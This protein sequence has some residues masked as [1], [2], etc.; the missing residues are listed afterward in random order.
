MATESP[1]G[2]GRTCT[3]RGRHATLTG[4]RQ[5]DRDRA[6]VAYREAEGKKTYDMVALGP[7]AVPVERNSVLL[8]PNLLSPAECKQ[9]VDDV[10]WHHRGG[11]DCLL[12]DCLNSWQEV[13]DTVATGQQEDRDSE[14]LGGGGEEE[15]PCQAAGL[16]DGPPAGTGARA[17]GS[18]AYAATGQ[19]GEPAY[20][21]GAGGYSRYMVE[22]LSP[23][24]THLF[25]SV[26][27]ERLLPL[28]S[29]EL[30]AVEEMMWRC[31]TV[32]GPTGLTFDGRSIPQRTPGVPLAELEYRYSSQE[33]AINRYTTGNFF[34]PHADHQALT[35]NVLLQEEGDA[36][37][38]GGTAFWREC[39]STEKFAH[40][41][42]HAELDDGG[43]H[44]PTLCLRPTAGVGVV[45]NG[46]VKHAGRAV[47]A[48]V[49]HVLVASLSML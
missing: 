1:G 29:T 2:G 14:V 36:F 30:P 17:G 23:A 47:T 37:E 19:Y 27:R 11:R 35:L 25:Q 33:P 3:V 44:A 13:T 21:Y 43:E 15:A 45:F 48:G 26:L 39:G 31:S 34:Q 24:T 12:R 41:S 49:R 20:G 40:R 16:A 5:A 28:L 10:E 46:K 9:L 6:D 42:E 38:G 7:D 18:G 4:I 22:K 8:L 32:A